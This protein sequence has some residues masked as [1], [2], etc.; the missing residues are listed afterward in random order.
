MQAELRGE[1][2]DR[3]RPEHA[4]I[5]SSP[6]AIG[7]QILQLETIYVVD[8]A[9]QNHLGR[10]ALDPAQRHLT[11]QRD[12]VLIQ[13]PPAGRIEVAKDADAIVVPAPPEIPRQRP[14]PF[15]NRS[16]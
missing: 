8:S 9:M 16:N 10:P 12:R 1:I 15:L 5:P 2:C 4:R 13:L 3:A 6:C 11:E 7:L 14:K